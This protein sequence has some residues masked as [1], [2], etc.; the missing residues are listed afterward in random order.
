MSFSALELFLVIAVASVILFYLTILSLSTHT[1]KDL[2]GTG[3]HE[4]LLYQDR[5]SHLI[6]FRSIQTKTITSLQTAQDNQLT[7]KCQVN[8][9]SKCYISQNLIRYY[10]D[11]TDCFESPLRNVSGLSASQESRRYLVFQPD[12]GGW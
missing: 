5:L 3:S 8:L 11:I 12:L 2:V 6:G 7:I 9:T 10:E 4:N 1:S